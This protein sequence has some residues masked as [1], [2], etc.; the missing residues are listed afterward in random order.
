MSENNSLGD[1]WLDNNEAWKKR[2]YNAKPEIKEC[3]VVTAYKNRCQHKTT[4][5]KQ[6][7]TSFYHICTDCGEEVKSAS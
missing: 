5:K 1:S 6:L 4:V 2:T 7:L 3:P